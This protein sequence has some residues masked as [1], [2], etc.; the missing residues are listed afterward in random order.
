MVYTDFLDRE[1]CLIERID[2]II[3]QRNISE[4]IS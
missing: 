4:T 1:Q 3:I 2:W